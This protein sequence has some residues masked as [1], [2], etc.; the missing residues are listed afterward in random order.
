M[1]INLSIMVSKISARRVLHIIAVVICLLYIVERVY[2]FWPSTG[3]STALPLIVPVNSIISG[4]KVQVDLPVRLKIPKIGVNSLIEY[5]GVEPNGEM[6]VPKGPSNVG[7]FELG[8][9]PGEVG[10]AVMAGH[11]GWKDGIPAVFDRL[12]QLQ[13][14]DKISVE[15]EKKEEVTF[16][17]REIRDFDPSANSNDIFNSDD[18][19]S[20]LNLITCE[21]V[22]NK[23]KQSYSSRLVIFADRD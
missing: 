3:S 21:G 16:T 10:S 15:N 19:R 8:V 7:W 12:S 18:G 22:W 9:R 2:Y 6:G 20:H 4:Q 14:G 23:E 17:V 1:I 13:V 11:Y 5:V